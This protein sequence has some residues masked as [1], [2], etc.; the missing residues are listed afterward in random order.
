MAFTRVEASDQSPRA[1]PRQAAPPS[2]SEHRKAKGG[3]GI[4]PPPV[5]GDVED[6]TAKQDGGQVGPQLRLVPVGNNDAL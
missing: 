2:Q 5:H 4:G 6:E 3:D 1:S